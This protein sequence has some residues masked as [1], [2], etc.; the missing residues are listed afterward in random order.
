MKLLRFARTIK[1]K[2]NN[3]VTSLLRRTG[4]FRRLNIS[5]VLLIL[6]SSIFL[7]FFSFYNYLYE[8]NLNLDRYV[9]LL[10]QNME[11]KIRDI[12]QDYEDIAIQFYGNGGIIA[13]LKEN[14]RLAGTLS[15]EEKRRYE[16]NCYT[17]ENMLYDMGF[18]QRHIMNIQFVS[19]TRQ[20]RMVEANGYY[21]GGIIRNPDEF[22]ES[23][24]YLLPQDKAGYPV[25]MDSALQTTTFYKNEQNIYGI[26]N[27]ITLGVSVYEPESRDFL[28]VLLFNIDLHA[29]SDIMDGYQDY[30]DGN[31]F[32]IGEDGVLMWF[33]PSITA[34]SFPQ[35]KGLLSEMM[36]ARQN[37]IRTQIEG[38]RVLLAY[39]RIP[40]SNIFAAYVADLSV[41]LA[42]T[43][44]VRNLCILV[45]LGIVAACFIISYHVTVSISDPIR[46]LVQVMKKTG[47]GKW[48]A[49][50]E[51]RGKDEIT[52]LGDRF[53]QMADKTNQLIDQ[54]YLSE[55]KRQRILLSSKNAQ[56]DAMLM[57]INPHFLY[58]TLDIIRWEAIYEAN[59]ESGVSRMIEK[60]SNLYRMGMR[61]GSDT[62]PLQEGIDHAATYLEVINFRHTEKI[63][64]EVEAEVDTH[65]C[66]IP[67]FI[68][69]PI[70]ENAVVHAFGDASSG[71]RIRIHAYCEERILHICVR[72]NGSGMSPQEEADLQERLEQEDI[73]DKSIGLINVNQR[74]RL[75]YGEKYGIRFTSRQGQ[76]SDV[77]ITLPLRTRSENMK[78]ESEEREADGISGSDC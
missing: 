16:E 60:F 20:Y 66:Y 5:F 72:D 43:Y 67:Q 52:I 15:E 70:M 62:I 78:W 68:L 64:L 22:Y 40:G 57:Q 26:A 69:Q 44:R 48:S 23:E 2:W 38:V 65:G 76:G 13:A 4:I 59:G 35:N 11:L 19:P 3:L 14:E 53:N 55:I 54:V 9:S 17:I 25:W 34:P 42:G 1:E 58:N 37:I 47:D 8:I 29:F 56:L 31:T 33:N 63:L 18:Q 10:V 32:L 71:R 50:Y 61:T 28:G 39:E 36:A 75:F 21:R 45:L 77:E 27:I 30:N 74:I 49:R 73:P 46:Q 51:N 6:T 41:L 7:T 12:M 24:F